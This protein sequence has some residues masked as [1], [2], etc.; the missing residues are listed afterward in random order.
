MRQIFKDI[1]V[2]LIDEDFEILPDD[3]VH[4]EIIFMFDAETDE[5]SD[6]YYSTQIYNLVYVNDDKN[7]FAKKNNKSIFE[8]LKKLVQDGHDFKIGNLKNYLTK[9]IN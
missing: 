3:A 9:T 4:N 8:M 7:L 1:K 6:S 5:Y 2:G